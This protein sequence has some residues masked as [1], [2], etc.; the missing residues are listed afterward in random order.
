MEVGI[1]LFA[2]F[3]LS[4]STYPSFLPSRSSL[5]SG[6]LWLGILHSEQACG[7][8]EPHPQLRGRTG[9]YAYAFVHSRVPQGQPGIRLPTCSACHAS[10]YRSQGQMRRIN[11][12]TT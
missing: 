11:R 2:L 9:L 3:L 10:D 1:G 12:C 8:W 4:F 5:S 6:W 7:W